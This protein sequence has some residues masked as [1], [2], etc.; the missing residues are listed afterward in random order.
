MVKRLTVILVFCLFVVC[1]FAGGVFSAVAYQKTT[2]DLN[3]T[4]NRSQDVYPSETF[5]AP[6][7]QYPAGG[8]EYSASCIPIYPDTIWQAPPLPPFIIVPVVHQQIGDTW[9][10]FQ[11]NGSVGRMI[12]VTN[13]G[14]AY[15][16]WHYTAGA[17]PGNPRS[18]RFTAEFPDHSFLTTDASQDPGPGLNHN[19][20][21]CN[22]TH[23]HNGS[24]VVIYH[25]TAPSVGF[26]ASMLAVAANEGSINFTRHFDLPDSCPLFDTPNRMEWPKGTAQYDSVTGRDYIH[27]VGTEGNTAANTWDGIGYERCYIDPAN[28]N[29]L[30]CQTYVNG[31]ESTYT[32]ANDAALQYPYRYPIGR[33]S[34]SCE[35]AVITAVS[36]VSKKV[37]IIWV[38]AADTLNYDCHYF[39]DV[40]YAESQHLGD[41]WV[42][43][44][45]FPPTPIN[46]TNFASTATT[47]R[48]YNDV[49]ACYDYNDSLHIIYVTVEVVLDGSGSFYPQRARLYHWSKAKGTDVISTA[50]WGGPGYPGAFCANIAKVQVA[51]KDPIYHPDSTYLIATWSQ[52]NLNDL[53]AA[54]TLTNSELYGSIS[55]DGGEFWGQA[56]D[57]T[58]TH[59]PG[60]APGNCLSEHWHSLA[61]NLYNGD[62]YIQY[63]CDNDPGGAITPEGTWQDDPVM[64]VV[65]PEWPDFCCV[66]RSSYLIVS[67]AN[68]TDPP[69]K[70]AP[71]G[72]RQL[73]LK[74]YNIGDGNCM[75][76]ATGDLVCVQGSWSSSPPGL[77][78]KDTTAAL[79]FTVSGAGACN[80]TFICGYVR[81]TTN[82]AGGKIE[83][84]PVYA[85]V[86][87]DYYACP[88]SGSSTV[89]T[90]E[91][92]AM[93]LYT[94]ANCEE[95]IYDTGASSTRPDTSYQVFFEESNIIAVATATD[96]IV[97]RF[98][99]E[100]II[101]KEGF[102]GA[103]DK[104]YTVQCDVDWEPD[105]WL[106]Y[107]KD[108][109]IMPPVPACEQIN[110]LP[111]YWWEKSKQ[112]K[113]FKDT[114][115][116]AYKHIVIEYV[117]VKRKVAPG[118][119]P[120]QTPPGAYPNTYIG[121]MADIDCPYDTIRLAQQENGANKAG[122]DAVNNIAWQRGYDYTGAHPSYNG[123]YCAIALANG[124]R[125]GESTVPYGAYNVK[126]HL[127]LSPNN[128]WG[129]KQG[130]L[131]RLAADPLP[132]NI[133]NG[134]AEQD[135]AVDRA[136][137]FTAR[138]IPAGNDPNASYSFTVVKVVAPG[139]DPTTGLAL[140]REYVDTARAIVNRE[141]TYPHGIP[142]ICGDLNGDGSVDCL[143]EAVYLI[144]FCYKNGPPPPCPIS[145]ADVNGDGL[146]GLGDVVY[147]II[148]C[149]KNGPAP[150]CPGLY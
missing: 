139:S 70:V 102:A 132:A 131:Y 36:P 87:N 118:W 43:G 130:D 38:G 46:I 40:V 119:W 95:V 128:G 57:L 101:T 16:A 90:L 89:D 115:P 142:V 83:D 64:K 148:Y 147:L 138:Q 18:V 34:R 88:D 106:V 11:K 41:E 61:S 15:S 24:P 146:I 37:A 30:T 103:Q 8:I 59:T 29:Q 97:G 76:Q 7:Y 14:Y 66:C 92:G 47:E 50:I 141:R 84:I 150:K 116:S 25:E 6:S 49:S 99:N 93:W 109:Y 19:S 114:A 22:V 33:L 42:N 120:N 27:I 31:A 149:Y 140:M 112:I 74:I 79:T 143:A 113:F 54:G 20:G 123:Y 85:V 136:W 72:S 58:G 82:E 122:Y 134:P 107:T 81:I 105:F 100:N 133:E 111:W 117:T 110:T 55:R 10:D 26:R 13:N 52:F 91:N 32:I 44:T 9:Y 96:T 137:V 69:L 60:C 78:P 144:T 77:A 51:A 5:Q 108:I 67:P 2:N 94:N 145:R 28:P 121:V 35:V 63:I 98:V 71:G 125:P 17:Y 126:N 4:R 1:I 62:L 127:H 124:G 135:S 39:S 23:L 45:N 65:L 75:W 80:G 12:S 3:K 73:A 86:A 56:V 21:Y 129:W 48:V 104:L 68:W 53:N